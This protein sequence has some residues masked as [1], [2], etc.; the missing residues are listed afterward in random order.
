[1][2]AGHNDIYNY[3]GG[4]FYVQ[5]GLLLSSFGVADEIIAKSSLY[6]P[7]SIKYRRSRQPAYHFLLFEPVKKKRKRRAGCL[8]LG[9][10][11]LKECTVQCSEFFT[12]ELKSPI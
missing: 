12:L 3:L 8:D 2:K 11:I 4:Q 5:V 1:V 9:Q 6:T 10:C 7:P